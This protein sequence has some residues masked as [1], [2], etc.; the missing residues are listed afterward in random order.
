MTDDAQSLNQKAS[1]A[2]HPATVGRV[3][4]SLFLPGSMEADE[5]LIGQKKKTHVAYADDFP[6]GGIGCSY[7]KIY[8]A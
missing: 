7:S 2:W 1:T 8:A 5:W 6:G 3:V 4:G